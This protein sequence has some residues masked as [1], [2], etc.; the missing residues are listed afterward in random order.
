MRFFEDLVDEAI[1]SIYR[2]YPFALSRLFFSECLLKLFGS[3]G[4]LTMYFGFEK[5]SSV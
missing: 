2:S 3:L 4:V 5:G 1:S